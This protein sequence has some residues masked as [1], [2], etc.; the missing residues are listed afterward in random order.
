[1][2]FSMSHFL[3]LA[4]NVYLVPFRLGASFTFEP[5]CLLLNLS[6]A[7][8]QMTEISTHR[9]YLMEFLIKRIDVI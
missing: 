6:T 4:I 3:T 2:R 9:C 7:C 8:A 5:H 1:M